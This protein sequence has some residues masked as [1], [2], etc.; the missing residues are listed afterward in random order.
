MK[1]LIAY[2]LPVLM[3]LS[4]LGC[5]PKEDILTTDPNA[6]LSFSE[7]TVLFDTVFTQTGTITKR[8]LV[9]NPNEKAVKIEEIKLG[10]APQSV[11]K[12]IIDGVESTLARNIELRGKD[13]LYILVRAFI[14][15]N[16]QNTPF[17]VTDSITFLTN[18]QR[19]DVKLVAFG[20]NAYF[21]NDSVLTCN[22]VWGADKPHV[23]YEGVLVPKGCT[24]TIE[25]GARVHLSNDAVILVEGTLLVGVGGDKDHIVTFSG[26]RLEERFDAR[27]GQWNGI[28]FLQ[29]SQGN[30]IRYADIKNAVFGIRAGNPDNDPDYDIIIENSIIR[31]MFSAGILSFTSD[32]KATNTVITN[33]GQY[34]VAGLAGG[35]YEFIYC[36][37]ANY[38]T[39]FN[40]SDASFVFSDYLELADGNVLREPYNL[41]LLNSI[42]W[43]QRSDGKQ[44]EML[45]VNDGGTTSPILAEYSLLKTEAYKS[46]FGAIP[47]NIINV[48]PKFRNVS[49]QDFRLDTLSPANGAAVV[50][51]PV[52]TDILGNIRS[53][54]NPDMGA[55]ERMN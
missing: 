22:T 7:D 45:F 25:P 3:F 6:I 34:T 2:L 52:Q 10:K 38:S 19:Q 41:K 12:L 9:Y 8:L 23:I 55:Y 4:L 29:E 20:Q 16:N 51:P 44:D 48:D 11:Y 31:N 24:L 53:Q 17:L 28:W 13:S 50:F 5:E 14:D 21:Y 35:N 18:K 32:I 46:A 36:T 43:G 15:P 49:R 26:D 1:N 33:C 42:V 54:S 37:F 40:R 27:P 30:I 47:S 39:Q